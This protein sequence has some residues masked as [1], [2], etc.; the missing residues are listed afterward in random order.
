MVCAIV[1]RVVMGAVWAVPWRRL[2]WGRGNCE[3]G[4]DA[5]VSRC[6][7]GY[8]AVI[9]EV[10]E[11]LGETLEFSFDGCQSG[12]EVGEDRV[13]ALD[14][15]C[16]LV[17]RL[18]CGLEH[19]ESVDRQLGDGEFCFGLLGWLPFGGGDRFFEMVVE[20]SVALDEGVLVPITPFVSIED[21]LCP[22]D[23]SRHR[24]TGEFPF[25]RQDTPRLG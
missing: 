14:G 18:G 22:C 13:A 6:E 16:D 15:L 7:N 24:F 8:H 25:G 9:E 23:E 4:G 2:L 20:P 11:S 21:H 10:V 12:G 1:F 19:R 3:P 5:L 17:H